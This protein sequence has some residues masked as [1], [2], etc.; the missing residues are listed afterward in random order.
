[1]RFYILDTGYLN[2]DK[3]NVVAGSTMATRSRPAA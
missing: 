2:T 3:N 1:M